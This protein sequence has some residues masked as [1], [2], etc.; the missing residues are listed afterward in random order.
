MDGRELL[1]GCLSPADS[2]PN[3]GGKTASL[4]ALGLAVLMAKA[5]MF[6]PI[7]EESAAESGDLHWIR[8][9]TFSAPRIDARGQCTR[10]QF[11]VDWLLPIFV[12]D[13]TR[14]QYQPPGW[15][16]H[17]PCLREAEHNAGAAPRLLWFDRVFA[18]VG[19]G[20]SLQQSLSTFS[21]HVRR[22]RLILA[23]V[24]PASLALLDE[25][26]S[27][28]VRPLRMQ[29]CTGQ[30]YEAVL[31]IPHTGCSICRSSMVS[32]VYTSKTAQEGWSALCGWSI[33]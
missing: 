23:A 2:G 19:D 13:S 21:S 27:G 15:M 11:A 4:K 22:L 26:G 1:D 3:T 7:A 8:R 20:Q 33:I 24:T 12:H 31:G 18:D 6:L 16:M 14:M 28:T 30:R 5:G 32:A 17:C 29:E 9:V 25:V 10:V